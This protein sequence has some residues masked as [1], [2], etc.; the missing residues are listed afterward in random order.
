MKTAL[1]AESPSRPCY[2]RP[3]GRTH[4]GLTRMKGPLLP[5]LLLGVNG[6]VVLEETSVSLEFSSH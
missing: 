3:R 6:Y 2:P 5:L 4:A 1:R